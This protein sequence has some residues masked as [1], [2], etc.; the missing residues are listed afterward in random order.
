MRKNI[1]SDPVEGDCSALSTLLNKRESPQ[2]P[3]SI[4][5]CLMLYEKYELSVQEYW[6]RI[7]H[8]RQVKTIDK[9]VRQETA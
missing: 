1:L 7:Y 4:A 9:S 6:D 8:N 3:K 5:T 2:R